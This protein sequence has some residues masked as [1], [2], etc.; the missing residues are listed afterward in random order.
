MRGFKADARQRVRD[1]ET[2]INAYYPTVTDIRLQRSTVKT[3]LKTI[4]GWRYKLGFYHAP[5][6]LKALQRM[7]HYRRPETTGF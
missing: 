7:V 4:S 1:F 5:Y 6:E 2:V 3:L